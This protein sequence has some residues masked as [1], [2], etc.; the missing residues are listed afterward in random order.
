MKYLIVVLLII[1]SVDSVFSQTDE[2][3]IN[4]IF[5][6]LFSPIEYSSFKDHRDTVFINLKKD[7]TSF[8]FDSITFRNE[9]GFMVPTNIISEFC[10][11]VEPKDYVSYWN[12]EE[13]NRTDTIYLQTDTVIGLKPFVKCLT[14]DEKML[15]FEKRPIRQRIY[16]IN[17]ILFDDKR[18]NAVFDFGDTPRP[19]VFS[20]QKIFIKK[21]FGKW[22]IITRFEF[23]MS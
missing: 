4:S 10:K 17:N 13:L 12:Q 2:M 6:E 9:T 3:V 15:L 16:L 7:R 14:A 18:E 21:I 8:D 23:V 20:S 1:T 22:V 5:H 11:N 19:G